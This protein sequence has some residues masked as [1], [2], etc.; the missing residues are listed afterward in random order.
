MLS[1]R[2]LLY[3]IVET[4]NSISTNEVP[5]LIKESLRLIGNF[6]KCDR[7]YV[8]TTEEESGKLLKLAEWFSDDVH[9]YGGENESL[10]L[11]DVEWSMNKIFKERVLVVNNINDLTEE[12][13]REIRLM[14]EWD[15]RSYIILPI[16]LSD[17]NKGYLGVEYVKQEKEWQLIDINNLQFAARNIANLILRYRNE[18]SLFQKEQLY[19]S[20]FHTANDS[21]LIFENGVCMDCSDKAL[22]LFRCKKSDLLGLTGEELSPEEEKASLKEINDRFFNKNE[23]SIFLNEYLVK[24]PDGSRFYAEIRISRV[25]INNDN[26]VVVI[27]RDI[28]N[29]KKS[30]RLLKVRENFLKKRLELLL[31]PSKE[32]DQ[33]SLKELFDVNQ[34]QKLQDAMVDALGVSS[35]FA[36]IDGKPVT[37][38][39]SKNKICELINATEK[40]KTLCHKTAELLRDRM[41]SDTE[42]SY[43]NC[44]TC[45]F[46]DAFATI[47]VEGRRVGTWIIGQ[48]IPESYKLKDLKDYLTPLGVDIQQAKDLFHSSP[49]F[50]DQQFEKVINLLSVLSNE[51]STLGYNNLKLA[52]AIRE[53][54]IME[55]ELRDAKERAEAS[56]RLKSAFL[57]NLSHEIRTP[58]NGIVGFTDLLNIKGLSREDRHEYIKLI[59]QSSNQLLNIINDIIDISKIEAGQVVVNKSKFN[60][61]DLFIG[62]YSFFKIQAE[63]KGIELIIIND[64][65]DDKDAWINTD[66]IKMRQILTNLL[67]NAIKFTDSGTVK[68]E[69]KKNGNELICSVEDTGQGIDPD[70]ME[71][72]FDRFRQSKNNT[73]KHGGTG[74]GLAITKAYVEYLGGKIRV[75]P[76]LEKGTKFVF[77]VPVI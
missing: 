10:N 28:S 25:V 9:G 52:R 14:A 60:I 42:P 13:K 71:N 27:F 38:P 49:K 20:L 21:I 67:S 68:M 76:E 3:R 50:N 66:E 23:T 55:K 45:S 56:D 43:I 64:K 1:F 65:P 53:H 29:V 74:L 7:T 40:G 75:E 44:L 72:I 61:Y 69:Y 47:V 70:H 26:L 46:V 63:E 30:Y 77:T 32:I 15:V 51:L 4:N 48:V 31:S 12:A 22:E 8:Y 35:Y 58:M 73:A 36:D 24:R 41:G 17:K 39:A 16:I 34:L 59:K 11:A 54:V 19:Q 37:T 5:E 2:D 18:T 33:F 6:F 62:L 57:A